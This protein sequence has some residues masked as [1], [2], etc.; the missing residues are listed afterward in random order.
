M[1]LNAKKKTC[2]ADCGAALF[3]ILIAV[4]LFAALGYAIS[5]SSRGSGNVDKEKTFLLAAQVVQYASQIQNTVMRLQLAY[6]CVDTQISFENN[7]VSGYTNALS[8]SDKRCN[9]FDPAGGG[10]TWNSPPAGANDGTPWFYSGAFPVEI[11][12]GVRC[13][14]LGASMGPCTDLVLFLPKVKQ[15]VCAQINKNLLGSTTIPS[16]D[17]AGTHFSTGDFPKFNGTYGNRDDL[18]FD[19]SQILAGCYED[20]PSS[21]YYVFFMILIKKSVS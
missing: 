17:T 1:N 19:D 16:D 10:L 21:G 8:P 20:E 6:T 15:E 7:I 5:Q 3:I 13:V 11:V 12:S 14:S 9:V 18:N 2:S 4:A